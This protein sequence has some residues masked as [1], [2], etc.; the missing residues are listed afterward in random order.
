MGKACGGGSSLQAQEDLVASNKRDNIQDI[1][2]GKS[3]TS[4]SKFS[5][6]PFPVAVWTI[7]AFRRYIS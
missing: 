5:F 3:T 7:T 6:K 1:S 4:F 2:M